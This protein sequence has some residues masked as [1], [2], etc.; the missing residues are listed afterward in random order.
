MQAI[1]LGKIVVA[2]PGTP[3]PLTLSQIQ[4]A[5]SA[6]NV[7]LGP[8]N[9]VHRVEVRT[10]PADTGA[11]TV[12]RVPGNAIVATLAKWSA[13]G[14]VDSWHTPRVEGEQINPLDYEFDAAVANNGPIVTLWV[15]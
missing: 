11:V 2:T 13:G 5:A 3:V 8:A 4:A 6:Q 12:K 14:P 7:T 1:A 9:L 10:D 15:E